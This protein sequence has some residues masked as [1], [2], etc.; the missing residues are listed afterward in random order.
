MRRP[1]PTAESKAR[2]A[3]IARSLAGLLEDPPAVHERGQS[4]TA[5]PADGGG[6]ACP[7]CGAAMA[8]VGTQQGVEVDQCL[9][10][11][12]VWLDAGELE[13]LLASRNSEPSGETPVASLSQLRARMATVVPGEAAVHY[14]ECPR[15]GD[16][17]GRRN[18]GTISGVVVDECRRHGVLLDEGELQAIESFVRM[19]GE[20]IGEEVRVE[21]G[22]RAL[23]LPPEP[24]DRPGEVRTTF[25]GVVRGAA[26]Q[27]VADTIWSLL[28]RW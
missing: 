6:L 20:K 21:Q 9:E 28:F 1:Q 23:P 27:T 12:A 11:G 13:A 24:L 14:R 18:F 26:T 8:S 16:V 25:G 19:G 5:R 22:Q 2:A 4:H 7:C 10:C 15:C 17:M 3:R